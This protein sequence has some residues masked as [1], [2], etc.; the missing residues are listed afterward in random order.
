MLEIVCEDNL[1]LLERP[2]VTQFSKI[3]FLKNFS[4]IS[5]QHESSIKYLEIS[6]YSKCSSLRPDGPNDMKFSI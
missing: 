5:L 1:M 2:R 4:G 3:T 6:K